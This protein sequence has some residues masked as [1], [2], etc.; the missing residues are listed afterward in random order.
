MK[1]MAEKE[2]LFPQF[3]G[4]T[5]AAV[6]N[7]T[8]KGKVNQFKDVSS[9]TTWEILLGNFGNPTYVLIGIAVIG[10]FAYGEYADAIFIAG[11]IAVN[12]VIGIIQEVIA[13]NSLKEIAV[14]HKEPVLARRDGE[15][16]EIM[17]EEIVE[18]DLLI[19]TSGKYVY[20]DGELIAAEGLLLDESIITGESDYI[21][22]KESDEIFSGAFV[23]SGKG[24]YRATKVGSE[25]F[26]NKITLEAKRYIN[27]LSPLQRHINRI[28]VI[29]TYVALGSIGLLLFVNYQY[30]QMESGE[31]TKAAVSIISTLIPQGILLSMTLAFMVGVFSM[32]RKN[33]LVQK[34]NAIESLANIDVLCMDKT[35]TLTQ[36]ELELA[37]F[38]HLADKN[39]LNQAST[40]KL[41]AVF[42]EATLEKNK[43]LLAITSNFTQAQL[44]TA[45]NTA[46]VNRQLPFNSRDKLSGVEIRLGG[47]TYKVILG[48]IEVVRRK[49]ANEADRERI[50]SLNQ[51]YASL[52]QRNLAF[53]YK[54]VSEAEERE[55][56]EQT[57]SKDY[58]ALAFIS[59]KD[60]LRLGA[61]ETLHN[62]LERGV[63]P[64]IISGDSPE[65]IMALVKQLKIDVLDKPITGHE[66]AKISGGKPLDQLNEKEKILWDEAILGHD[67]F[68]SVTPEQKVEIVKT[69]QQFYRG[70]AMIGDGVNDALAIK[71]ANLGISLA[72]GAN[73]S[74]DISDIVLLDN[75]LRKLSE[76][77][78]EGKDI[79]YNTLRTTKVLVIK[80]FYSAILIIG[81]LVLQLHFPFTPR[82]V[83]LLSFVNANFPT[84]DFLS[85]KGAKYYGVDF[86]RNLLTFVGAGGIISGAMILGTTYYYSNKNVEDIYIN[87]AV[88]TLLV[89]FGLINYLV[90]AND[91]FNLLKLNLNAKK[92]LTLAGTVLT[93]VVVVYLPFLSEFFEMVPLKTETLLWLS[94]LS[95]IYY[96]TFAVAERG[97]NYLANWAWP[98]KIYKN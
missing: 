44:Q 75:D 38:I 82:N 7:L 63:K 68:A 28:V 97:V 87:S 3:A 65:T 91:S 30:L 62:F 20:V 81:A 16:R 79:I 88:I 85:D 25:S 40:D 24:I 86:M 69:L 13:R 56:W 84:V 14:I 33:I 42:C 57:E 2:K 71:Q 92:V 32:Y 51:H 23:I 54:E 64:L 21:A 10:L 12:L 46:K 78:Q 48:A 4:Q 61:N 90:T 95:L 34:A 41:T 49:L 93:Y 29:M 39:E 45:L 55:P 26:I 43:T 58:K 31:V 96:L 27:Y 60:K 18:G 1:S 36:N 37:N 76:V 74:R 8:L 53:I 47:K 19:L 66:L 98:N 15:D 52:G 89:M 50:V 22:K 17:P 67:I 80:N 94:A 83:V 35:G 6:E 73:V 72:A 11:V 9:K 5:S 70:V 77:I 59:I